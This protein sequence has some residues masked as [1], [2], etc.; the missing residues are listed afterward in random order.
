GWGRGG[1]GR[2]KAALGKRGGGVVWFMAGLRLVQ[3]QN[4]ASAT[5]Q[6]RQSS[7]YG[8]PSGY[9][10]NF[11]S[12]PP[13]DRSAGY[14]PTRLSTVESPGQGF[15]SRL[16]IGCQPGGMDTYCLNRSVSACPTYLPI[17][18]S[19]CV[20]FFHDRY[21]MNSADIR[22]PTPGISMNS[23]RVPVLRLTGTKALR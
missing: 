14:I 11:R 20:Q 19:N 2:G 22:E 5:R 16:L 7:G 6:W 8:V 15:R 18:L 23:S 9:S 13:I 12:G 1:A 17:S 4:C 3:N 10:R 21:S